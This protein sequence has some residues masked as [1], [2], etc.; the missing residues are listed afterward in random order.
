MMIGFIENNPIYNSP[1]GFLT[2]NTDKLINVGGYDYIWDTS[3]ILR[4]AVLGDVG[5]DK[6]ATFDFRHH[7]NASNIQFNKMAALYYTTYKEWFDN[8][9]I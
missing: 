6:K 8:Y 1:G 5:C 3:Q 4:V 7:E 9:K 2:F